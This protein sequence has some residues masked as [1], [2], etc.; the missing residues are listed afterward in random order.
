MNY[1]TDDI[2]LYLFPTWSGFSSDA[3]FTEFPSTPQAFFSTAFFLAGAQES[4]SVRQCGGERFTIP[5][6]ESN[7]DFP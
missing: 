5:E 6:P 4:D 3:I 1:G 7:L 2:S